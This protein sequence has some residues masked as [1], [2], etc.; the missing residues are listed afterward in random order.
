MQQA[1]LFR[2]ERQVGDGCEI[3]AVIVV[4]LFVFCLRKSARSAG[5]FGVSIEYSCLFIFP[6]MAQ[7]TQTNTAKLYYFAEKDRL[8][9]V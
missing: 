5:D 1:A 7:I 2:R 9:E 4:L 3:I 8:F 6:Q